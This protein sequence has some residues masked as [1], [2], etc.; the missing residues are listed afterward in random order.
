MCCVQNLFVVHYHPGFGTAFD[1][2]AFAVSTN[3]SRPVHTGALFEIGDMRLTMVAVDGYRLA[4][5][6]YFPEESTERTMLSI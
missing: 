3:E 1:Q 5:R 6:R 2:T 4:M